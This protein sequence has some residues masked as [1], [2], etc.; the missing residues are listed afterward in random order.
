MTIDDLKKLVSYD[1]QTGVFL[2]SVSPKPGVSAGDIAGSV[3][4][5]GYLRICVKRRFYRAN[6]LA[7]AL[8]T[9][10]WPEQQV[11][12]INH[13]KADNRWCNL[14]DVSQSDNQLNRSGAQRNNRHGALG[15]TPVRGRLR[16]SIQ[17]NG[18]RRVLGYFTSPGE[19]AEAR[20]L[21]LE[22]A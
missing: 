1:P 19:V 3:S 15:A 4:S 6:R 5:H 9:G 16:A 8:Q 20:R 22:A 18:R 13:D 12:H 10:R 7:F 17:I 2:W 21:A 14:R 11:D